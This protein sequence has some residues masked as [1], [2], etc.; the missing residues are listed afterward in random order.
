[1]LPVLGSGWEEYDRNVMGE[2]YTYLVLAYGRDSAWRL[3]DVA[4]K[5]ASAGW[6]GDT[7]VFYDNPDSGL[8]ALVWVSQWDTTTDADEFAQALLDYGSA[9][10]GDPTTASDGALAWQATTDGYVYIRQ[11]GD[12]IVWLMTPTRDQQ[13]AILNSLSGSL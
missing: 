3:A 7:Y 11:Y 2:W 6:G 5:T 13:F 8:T 12:K 4:A 1:M 9:R 10:W